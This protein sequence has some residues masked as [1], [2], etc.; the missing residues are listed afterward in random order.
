MEKLGGRTIGDYYVSAIPRP[1]EHLI[2]P[3]SGLW[4]VKAVGYYASRTPEGGAS[5]QLE[6]EKLPL[7][8]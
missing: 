7:R 3:D 8:S 4:L 6:V 5:V 2:G 1:N